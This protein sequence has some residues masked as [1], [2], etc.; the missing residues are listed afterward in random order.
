MERERCRARTIFLCP[1][2]C[3][4]LLDV[5]AVIVPIQY[6]VQRLP[7]HVTAW[8]TL[9]QSCSE[10]DDGAEVCVATLDHAGCRAGA[11]YALRTFAFASIGAACVTFAV[12]AIMLTDMLPSRPVARRL[13]A[14]AWLLLTALQTLYWVTFLWQWHMACPPS[15]NNSTGATAGT[16]LSDTDGYSIGFG[17]VLFMITSGLGAMFAI[18]L[19]F[20]FVCCSMFEDELFARYSDQRVVPLNGDSDDEPLDLSLA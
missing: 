5:V 11:I 16:A 9:F 2:V 8:T 13:F 14:A 7:V 19:I 12:T 3:F 15:L 1:P 4:F 17:P 6:Y 18:V 20:P 10:V